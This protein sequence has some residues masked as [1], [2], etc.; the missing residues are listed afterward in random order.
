MEG[1][2]SFKATAANTHSGTTSTKPCNRLRPERPA[3]QP[4]AASGS[5]LLQNLTKVHSK[6]MQSETYTISLDTKA[7]SLLRWGPQPME[8]VSRILRQAAPIFIP[9]E[10][11]PIFIPAEVLPLTATTHKACGESVPGTDGTSG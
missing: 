8:T 2:V 11:P 9:A 6:E 10:F 7:S 4:I 5:S 1:A 3:L